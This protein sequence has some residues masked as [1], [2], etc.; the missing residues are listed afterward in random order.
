MRNC[1]T[2]SERGGML[3]DVVK[4]KALT[5]TDPSVR[6]IL[7]GHVDRPIFDGAV[8]PSRRSGRRGFATGNGR[9][10]VGKGGPPIRG[11]EE[12]E[13]CDGPWAEAPIGSGHSSRGHR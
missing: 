3:S 4:A 9:I 12:S 13:R 7:I 2:F 5:W 1:G 6:L 10:E 8:G 11:N